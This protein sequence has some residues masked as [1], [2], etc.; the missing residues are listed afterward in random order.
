MHP[1]GYDPMA[2]FLFLS[3]ECFEVNCDLWLV[4]C[5]RELDYP[6]S[7]LLSAHYRY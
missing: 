7:L 3:K 2:V 1:W 5:L 6:V 4:P